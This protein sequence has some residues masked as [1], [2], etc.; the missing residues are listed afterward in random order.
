VF[1]LDKPQVEQSVD[2]IGS[3]LTLVHPD[4]S[5]ENAKVDGGYV[6]ALVP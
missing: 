5:L 6:R 2:S 3:V 4:I 1:P